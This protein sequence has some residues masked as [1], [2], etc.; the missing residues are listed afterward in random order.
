MAKNETQQSQTITTCIIG[1]AF[2]ERMQSKDKTGWYA[3]FVFL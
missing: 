3:G 1:F 2:F